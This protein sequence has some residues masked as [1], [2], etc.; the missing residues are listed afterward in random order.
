MTKILLSEVPGQLHRITGVDL[1]PVD[2]GMDKFHVLL[3]FNKGESA[4]IFNIREGRRIFS[5]R[6]ALAYA[7]N[8]LGMQAV[9]VLLHEAKGS[10]E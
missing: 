1:I 6:K 3:H 7:R 4:T 9:R 8:V 2:E 5:S 10:E